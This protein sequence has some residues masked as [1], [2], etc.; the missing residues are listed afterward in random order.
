[1]ARVAGAGRVVVDW[2]AKYPLAP[3]WRREERVWL[4]ADDGT[5]LFAARLHG[6]A[7]APFAVV[8]VHGMLNSSRSPKVHAFARRLAR[9]VHVLAPDLRGHGASRGR[10][11]LGLVEPGDL[12]VAVT[13][14]ASTWGVPVVSVGTSLGGLVALLHA[15]VHG[16][17]AGVVAVSSPGFWMRADRPGAQRIR[18]L[19]AGRPGRALA[20]A[21][22]RTR[23]AALPTRGAA[24]DDAV[25][26]IAPAFTLIVHDA[27]DHFFGPEHAEHLHDVASEPK[28]LWW[29]PGD[30]HGID[31]L[32]P[33]FADEL[34]TRLRDRVPSR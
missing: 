21:L 28:E 16:G 15:G 14:A 8:L 2:A 7:N 34:L 19:V 4:R 25:A 26:A 6:P 24:I 23:L 31:L 12:D 29:R 9:D 33:S 3:R 18:R 30:G 1:M 13:L 5:Q 32:T 20:A 27:D 22:L 11:T 17:V 10:S